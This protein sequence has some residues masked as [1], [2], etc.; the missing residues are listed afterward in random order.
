MIDPKFIDSLKR[1]HVIVNK[2]VTSS[3]SGER[4]STASG[5]GLIIKDY[6]QYVRG[7][8]FRTIDWRIFARTDRLHVKQYEEDKNLTVHIIVDSSSSMDYGK[9]M[10]KFDYAAMIGI[11]FAYLT[12][13][14]NEKFEFSTFADDL[15]P[16]RAR[17]GKRQLAVMVNHLNHLKIKGMSNFG[18]VMAHYKKFITSRSLIVI[19]SD[20][21]YNLDEIEKGLARF[22]KHEL[23]IIQVLDP[24][25]KNMD[26][27]GSIK[28]HD[29]ESNDTLKTYISRRMKEKYLNNLNNHIH[30]VQNICNH[31]NANF[32]CATTDRPIFDT[33]FDVLKTR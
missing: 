18:R 13:K 25:E 17:R 11:G 27:D 20:F 19:I 31:L 22:N 7:D 29:S 1:F 5:K 15:Y 4:M 24:R 16:Y 12:M 33:F 30:E 32:C 23:K 3:Y 21:L 8:D 10:S 2:R 6:R 9:K 14:D 28:L 26:M